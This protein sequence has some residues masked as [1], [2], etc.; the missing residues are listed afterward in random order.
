M[1]GHVRSRLRGR[2]QGL[3]R[4]LPRR[5]AL[6]RAPR[7][8]RTTS[9]S[10]SSTRPVKGITPARLPPPTRCPACPATQQFTSVGYGA[11]EVTNGPGGHQYLYDDV[12]MRRD[13]HAERDQPDL[14]ADLDEPLHRQR[15]HLLRRL[16]RPQLPGHDATIVAAITITGDA[17][18]RSTNVDYRLDT[19]VG[20]GVPRPVRGAA[21][22]LVR[23][24]ATCL[25]CGAWA[26][27]SRPSRTRPGARSSTSSRSGTARRC[28]SC[29]PG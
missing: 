22:A 26:T 23:Q 14:A 24:A 20:P 27:C 9:P 21:V 5:P 19:A 13:R 18:C 25:W 1:R 8:T 10:S 7:A 29:A 11:Y 4:H 2:R 16:G 15:R 17:V 28:S 3:L 6:H 12:R